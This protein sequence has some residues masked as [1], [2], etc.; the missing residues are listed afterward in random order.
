MTYK[1]LQEKLRQKK[2]FEWYNLSLR[3]DCKHP[4]LDSGATPIGSADAHPIEDRRKTRMIK[5][6]DFG[7]RYASV[8][9]RT[10]FG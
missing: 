4:Y 3:T 1:D 10:M 2:M 5:E 9:T 6:K 7:R 8:S